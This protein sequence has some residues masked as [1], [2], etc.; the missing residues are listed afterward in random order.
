MENQGF[1]PGEGGVK[2]AMN[3]FGRIVFFFGSYSCL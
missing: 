3:A 2:R 1:F